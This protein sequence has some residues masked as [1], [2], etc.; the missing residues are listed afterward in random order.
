MSAQPLCQLFGYE[1]T[2]ECKVVLL[3][4]LTFVRKMSGK[5]ETNL[6]FAPF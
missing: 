5:K 6:A 2:L 3:Y 1:L 4:S